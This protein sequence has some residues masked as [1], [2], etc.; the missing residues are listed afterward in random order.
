ME[1]PRSFIS[2]LDA[3]EIDYPGVR[4]V[5]EHCLKTGDQAI[6]NDFVV[7]KD[8]IE[9]VLNRWEIAF[10]NK[11]TSLIMKVPFSTLM[12][13]DLE[14]HEQEQRDQITDSKSGSGIYQLIVALMSHLNKK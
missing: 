4:A 1:F 14:L 13:I 11:Q 2:Y 9:W 8:A 6:Y 12:K 5:F 3:I 7:S 10:G